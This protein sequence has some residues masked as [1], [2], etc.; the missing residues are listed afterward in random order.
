[1]S[2]FFI[3]LSI[4]I[5]ALEQVWCQIYFFNIDI[6]PSNWFLIFLVPHFLFVSLF[7]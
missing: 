1:M 6:V 2:L 4:K 7:H 3:K 5:Y